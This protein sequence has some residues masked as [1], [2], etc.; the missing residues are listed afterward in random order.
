VI[1]IKMQGDFDRIL[2]D[3]SEREFL[4]EANGAA[5][6]GQAFILMRNTQGRMQG[7][8][9]RNILTFEEVDEDDAAF[10]G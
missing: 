4:A 2:I 9:V 6:Q 8:N 1:S 3:A 7:V 10:L 5:M